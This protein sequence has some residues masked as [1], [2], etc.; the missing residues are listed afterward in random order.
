MHLKLIGRARRWIDVE[1]ASLFN[2]A[3]DDDCSAVGFRLSQ[4]IGA[5]M[6]FPLLTIHAAAV[7]CRR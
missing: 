6:R 2:F 4:T 5:L 7:K 1:P 3:V